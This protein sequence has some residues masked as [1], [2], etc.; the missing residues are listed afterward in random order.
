MLSR[1]A[2]CLAATTVLFTVGCAS[3]PNRAQFSKVSAEAEQR[4]GTGATVYWNQ[5][6][7]ADTAAT[8]RVAELLAQ[9]LT[10]DGAVQVALL[11]NRG[12]QA[13]FEGFGIAQAELAQAGVLQNP[14]LSGVAKIG[15]QG[16]GTG[17]EVGIVQQFLSIL[18]LPMRKRIAA[19]ELVRVQLDVAN[20]VVDLATRTRQTFYATQAA[21][22]MQ[23]LFATVAEAARLGADVAQR[24]RE[25][26]NISELD[27][28]SEQAL[29]EQ[30]KLD[31]ASAEAA[32]LE[33]RESLSVLLGVW[34]NETSWT[35]SGRLLDVPASTVTLVGLERAAIE[36]RLDLAAARQSVIH[37]AQVAGIDRVNAVVPEIDLGASFERERDGGRS[38]NPSLGVR[39]PVFDQGQA[40][41]AGSRSR[42]R[43]EQ[44]RYA[45]LAI[46]I[47][48]DVRRYHSRM[49]AARAR[50][51]YLR[52][53]II[54]LRIK[55]V[56]ETQLFYNGMLV[57]VFQ[58]LQAKRDEVVAGQ[59]YVEA[60]RDY[61][62]ARASLEQ[63]IGGRLPNGGE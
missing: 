51:D 54:P 49:N 10:V 37:E 58:L 20:Q 34:G 8:A 2:R 61:W 21:E 59:Q 57:G 6:T 14:L 15:M 43:R 53:V 60:V 32:V 39:I 55:I 11:N 41:N 63:A 62:L 23:E 42:I 40:V 24:Q 44:E 38:V 16:I 22:Q 5:G 29:Y 35:L 56:D 33:Q 19:S 4:L 25:A 1:A 50:A 27:L 26:G 48:S 52:A 9:P 28:A 3:A 13:T 30:A 7:A 46:E 36:R 47:R 45:A 31:L 12:L 18:Q 17:Y